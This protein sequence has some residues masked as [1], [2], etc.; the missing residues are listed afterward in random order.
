[1]EPGSDPTIQDMLR[2]PIYGPGS[3][4]SDLIRAQ[5]PELLPEGDTHGHVEAPEGTTVLALRYGDGVVVPV[6][7][8]PP[9]ASR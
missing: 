9:R 4:F 5:S 3:S 6:T 7:A 8:G 1:M 2:V